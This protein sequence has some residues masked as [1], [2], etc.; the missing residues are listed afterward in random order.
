[1][2]TGIRKVIWLPRG[3]YADEDTNG[4]IDN[5]A[6]FV[7]PGVV[8]LAWTDDALDPQYEISRE[9]YDILSSTK[10]ALGRSIEVIK[11]PTPPPMYYSEEECQGRTLWGGHNP[12]EPGARMAGSYVNFYLANGAY[13]AIY[14]VVLEVYFFIG[15]QCIFIYV[16][17]R[18]NCVS[19]LPPGNRRHCGELRLFIM[20]VETNCLT[21]AVPK[22]VGKDLVR[23]LSG[24]QGGVRSR[25]RNPL[26][27]VGF[28]LLHAILAPIQLL[29]SVICNPGGGNIHCI[30][31]Q[32]PVPI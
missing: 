28:V 29:V 17:I 14:Y 11:I 6:C 13:S 23:S 20:S 32:E 3:L 24:S 27:F 15:I 10:D 22:H 16:F 31:Q 1:M 21:R 12:R 25:T 19:I 8:L 7:R 9:A 26:R 5:F 4:H 30:T 18:R 2:F